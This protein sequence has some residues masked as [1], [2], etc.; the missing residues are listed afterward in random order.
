MARYEGMDEILR[1]V[2][3]R[4]QGSSHTRSN[5]V[6]SS[7]VEA[8]EPLPSHTPASD[9][10]RLP[11]PT[12]DESYESGVTHLKALLRDAES[13]RDMLGEDMPHLSEDQRDHLLAI[14]H[15]VMEELWTCEAR[16]QGVK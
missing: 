4:L 16:L 8:S 3:E 9:P 15:Q 12:L 2:I 6:S 11:L 1:G 7:E 14:L 13:V 5:E 10:V